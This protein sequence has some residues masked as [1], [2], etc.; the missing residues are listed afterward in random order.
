MSVVKIETTKKFSSQCNSYLIR[1]E[2]DTLGNP[3][4]EILL[5]HPECELPEYHT[6]DRDVLITLRSKTSSSASAVLRKG[7][8]I[9]MEVTDKLHK[10][11]L[12]S[13]KEFK[14]RRESTKKD[15]LFLS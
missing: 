6:Q 1:G 5:L 7:L 11:F 15:R 9:F 8:E 14:A 10:D 3:L 12:Y 2:S 13:L 4:N